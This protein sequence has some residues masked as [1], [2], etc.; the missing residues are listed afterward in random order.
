MSLFIKDISKIEYN[1]VNS[2]V[3]L[4][5]REGLRVDYKVDFPRDLA[6][7][8]VAFANTAGGV[9]LIGVSANN[10]TNQP[11][12]II[13]VPLNPGLEERVTSITLSNIEPPISPEVKVCPYKSTATLPENDRAVVVVRVTQSNIAPH[14]DSNNTIWVRNHNVCSS[15]SLDIIEKLIE[16]RNRGAIIRDEIEQK[17]NKIVVDA[18]AGFDTVEGRIRYFEI[19]LSPMAPLNITF[20]KETDDFLRDQVN[21]VGHTNDILAKISGI[22]LVS[23]DMDT[24]RVR[25]FFS[26]NS[27]GFFI[28]LAPLEMP[29][30]DDVHAERVIQILAKMMRTGTRLFE[31]F[32]YFG[33]VNIEMALKEITGLQLTSLIRDIGAEF[34]E[35]RTSNEAEIKIKRVYSFDNIRLDEQTILLS[36]YSDLLRSFQV[37][38]E[39]D[40]LVTRLTRLTRVLPE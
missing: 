15:A 35:P 40:T 13:G 22:E 2:F 33:N 8:V 27:D 20:N 31:H 3:A 32:G 23:R 5:L 24:R 37:S 38:L 6:K 34:D 11:E 30:A 14:S 4:R 36:F 12:E 9:I 17:A 16:R 21:T 19:R 10:T 29:T 7:I 26:F 25:R 1:D 39:N 28:H 18:A